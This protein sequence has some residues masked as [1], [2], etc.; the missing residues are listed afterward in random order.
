MTVCVSEV[1]NV[2]WTTLLQGSGSLLTQL[3]HALTRCPEGS[4]NSMCVSAA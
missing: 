4:V 3:I 1:I 2:L